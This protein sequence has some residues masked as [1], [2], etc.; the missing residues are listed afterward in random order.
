MKRYI[1][2]DLRISIENFE[3]FFFLKKDKNMIIILCLT[4]F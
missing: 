3:D 2:N 4:K 1:K